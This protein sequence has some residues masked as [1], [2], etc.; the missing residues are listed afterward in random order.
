MGDNINRG[1]QMNQEYFKTHNLPDA[2]WKGWSP[3]LPTQDFQVVTM[4]QEGLDAHDVGMGWFEQERR[5]KNSPWK[6]NPV[7][8]NEPNAYIPKISETQLRS[9]VINILRK[10]NLFGQVSI[11]P[12]NNN[13]NNIK[14]SINATADRRKELMKAV[15]GY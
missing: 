14:L 6:I 15:R 1:T 4:K 11:I 13:V 8:I 10:Y 3:D 12:I 5:I 9:I 7:D 2:D